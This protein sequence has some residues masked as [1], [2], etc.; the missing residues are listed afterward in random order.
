MKFY[1]LVKKLQN[2]NEVYIILVRC[3]IKYSKSV[4]KNIKKE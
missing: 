3:G 2:E 4:F 1:D